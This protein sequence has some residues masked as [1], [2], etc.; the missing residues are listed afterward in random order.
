MGEIKFDSAALKA[1]R[2]PLRR[3]GSCFGGQ[4][5]RINKFAETPDDVQK[6]LKI[7]QDGD[8]ELY[9]TRPIARV[10]VTPNDIFS[11]QFVTDALGNNVVVLNGGDKSEARVTL[12]TLDSNGDVFLKSTDDNI[13]KAISD[14][15]NKNLI[16]KDP[17]DIVNMA[18]NFN[19]DEI[20]RIDALIEKL[21]N[22]KNNLKQAIDN[23]NDRARQ[24]KAEMAKDPANDSVVIAGHIETEA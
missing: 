19:R 22:A 3:T 21:K 11:V 20:A 16:F 23:N 24:Y 17:D 4:F 2:N 12:E 7:H 8:K 15:S 14:P 5:Y 13:A 9:I 1:N 10:K 18:N 6:C